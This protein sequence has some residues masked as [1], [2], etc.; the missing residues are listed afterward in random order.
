MITIGNH[1]QL[2]D[3]LQLLG[4]YYELYLENIDNANVVQVRLEATENMEEI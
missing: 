3:T 1:S 2:L 4:S